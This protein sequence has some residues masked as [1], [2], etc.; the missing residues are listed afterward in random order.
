MFSPS[1]C[2]RSLRMNRFLNFAVPRNTPSAITSST[3]A[4]ST[5]VRSHSIVM[6]IL[7]CHAQPSGQPLRQAL[8]QFA[9]Q[10]P[11][12]RA[13]LFFH[14]RGQFYKLPHVL[15]H[16]PCRNRIKLNLFIQKRRVAAE[17]DANVPV[18][19]VSA[20]IKQRPVSRHAYHPRLP[21]PAGFQSR[22]THLRSG[23]PGDRAWLLGQF[24]LPQT[25]PDLK[26]VGVVFVQQLQRILDSLAGLQYPLSPAVNPLL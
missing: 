9:P 25:P 24:D 12:S 11:C 3:P 13:R 23:V 14:R 22:S 4:T 19:F 18:L 10:Q 21:G 17:V 7:V 6:R 5:S 2:G 15:F 8:S 26:L 16:V 20:L 1:F